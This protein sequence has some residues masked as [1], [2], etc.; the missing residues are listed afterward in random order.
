VV[1]IIIRIALTAALEATNAHIKYFPPCATDKVQQADSFVISKIKD[2]W[3]KVR[4]QKDG[5]NL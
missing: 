1:G 4:Y 2:A 5:D 3:K